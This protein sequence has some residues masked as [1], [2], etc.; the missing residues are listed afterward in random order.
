MRKD[1][2]EIDVFTG[3]NPSVVSIS[4]RSILS[5]DGGVETYVRNEINS[6]LS[7]RM[8]Y[9]HIC[10][11]TECGRYFSARPYLVNITIF[12]GT[13]DSIQYYRIQTYDFEIS[14][15]LDE[16]NVKSIV[17]HSFINHSFH[18]IFI[19]LRWARDLGVKSSCYLHDFSFACTSYHLL[20]PSGMQEALQYCHMPEK[21]IK[22]CKNCVYSIDLE[23]YRLY[24][25]RL[26]S[27]VDYIFS[28]SFYVKQVFEKVHYGG[29][30]SR[31]LNV[32][33]R[34]L[35]T[36]SKSNIPQN[37]FS[38]DHSV[39]IAFYGHH[40]EYK[41][42]VKFLEIVDIFS[43]SKCI[44]FYCFSAKAPHDKRIKWIPHSAKKGDSANTL[45]NK[46]EIYNINC[47]FFWNFIPES[48]GISFREAWAT[49]LPILCNYNQA[50]LRALTENLGKI[51]NIINFQSLND[52][53]G[54]IYDFNAFK[55]LLGSSIIE[56]HDLMLVD[57]LKLSH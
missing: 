1:F 57:N 36:I 38:F 42:W 11:D 19:I 43:K 45:L 2:S 55:E 21:D 9:I 40:S 32:Q 37:N 6:A 44:S 27:L 16:L 5:C 52:L 29:F 18:R 26:Y 24:I 25:K 31:D 51:D 3:L 53:I 13:P 56:K 41:G 33:I 50:M 15:L 4:H 47:F 23:K 39:S 54:I 12:R 30:Y 8:Q 49:G 46:V 22:I 17:L 48:Y 34:P 10:P 14:V 20:R 35:H 28:P 7:K